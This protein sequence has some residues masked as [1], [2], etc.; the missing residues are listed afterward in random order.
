M[1]YSESTTTVAPGAAAASSS[2]REGG[3]ECRA[4]AAA[5]CGR[6]GAEALQVVVEVRHVDQGQ[7]GLRAAMTA[8][9][10]P[11]IHA[12]RRQPALGP[13]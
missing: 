7:V 9:A 5:A 11:A 1:P 3:V 2:G 4:A 10:A 6:V 8:R 12:R 13:Q